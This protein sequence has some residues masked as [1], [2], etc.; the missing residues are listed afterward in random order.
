MVPEERACERHEGP[1]TPAIVHTRIR[2]ARTSPIR[3]AFTH[4]SV[5]WLIDVDHPP[6]TGKWLRPFAHFRAADHFGQPTHPGDTLRSRLH[7]Q[8]ATAGLAPPSGRVVAL[9]SPRVA[10]HVFNPLSVYWC[11]NRDGTLDRVVAE[12]HN[13]YG[14]RHCYVV[15]PDSHGDALVPK[16]FYVSPFNDVDGT[17]RLHVP[18][19]RADGRVA[20]SV[21]L[22]RDGQ[23]P[24]TAS[25]TGRARPATTAEI[26]RT[27]LRAPLA[28]VLVSARIRIHGIRLWLR[29]LPVIPRPAHPDSM[30]V[31]ACPASGTPVS[32]KDDDE[33][34]AS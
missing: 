10:G 15:T 5:A 33:R 8:L 31:S 29:R 9:L 17:Y 3:H 21:T 1:P 6:I 28:P 32:R 30:T 27:Q 24:F 16:E 22:H 7:H 14:E 4:R 11:H 20:V 25:V 19:P 18:P 23:D 12:V 26:I 2:H 34:S 13:T